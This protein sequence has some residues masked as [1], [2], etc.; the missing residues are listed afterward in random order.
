M[1]TRFRIA[2]ASALLA[3]MIISISASAKG[4]FAFITIV[5]ANLKETVRTADRELTH[6]FFAFADFYRSMS[7]APADPGVGYEITRYYI[8]NNREVAFDKLH[9][10]PDTGFVFYDGMVN[11]SSEYDGK[12]YT[13]KTE[14][15]PIFESKLPETALA[16]PSSGKAV[17]PAQVGQ[18]AQQVHPS[19]L[20]APSQIMMPVVVSLAVIVLILFLSGRR[21]AVQ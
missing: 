15:K 17:E 3:A 6:D 9:Y 5:G 11:G 20:M 7:D 10:Y 8:D 4:G 19:R 1:F 16:E 2:F 14:I 18:P 21:R 12:W 13:A